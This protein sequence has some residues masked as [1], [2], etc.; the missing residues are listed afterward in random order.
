MEP[1]KNEV[2]EKDKATDANLTRMIQIEMLTNLVTSLMTSKTEEENNERV[3]DDDK[4]TDE[5]DINQSLLY[6]TL[7]IN[8]FDLAFCCHGH[9]IF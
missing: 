9:Q 1:S 8:G 3:D 7:D 6:I 2:D 4:A 5:A